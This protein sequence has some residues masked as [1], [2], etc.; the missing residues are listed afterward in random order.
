LSG[1]IVWAS[2]RAGANL[3]LFV[4]KADGRGIHRL[5]ETSAN[6]ALPVWSPDG[7]QIAF[8]SFSGDLAS[9]DFDTS[10]AQINVMKADGSAVRPLTAPDPQTGAVTW[11]PDGDRLA[12]ATHSHI[13]VMRSDGSHRRALR[14]VEG[15]EDWPSW[16]PDGDL[17]LVT[18]S[19]SGSEEL[20]TMRA[21][22]S[23]PKPLS[24]KGSEG[25]WSPDGRSI[26]FASDRD[27]EPHA[28]N[29][30]DWN[31][32]IY[33]TPRDGARAKRVTRIAGNDHWPPAWSPD[34]AHIAFTADG[35]GEN[36]EIFIADA[37]GSRVLNA[38]QHPARDVF[39]SWHR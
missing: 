7:K 8:V 9:L 20:L 39:P 13:D 6:E 24:Q 16:S 1:R 14:E 25:T 28:E 22:G 3:D 29:P 12:F 38:T 15:Y 11:A 4:M 19:R 5:T 18:S 31:E 2:N 37:D 10:P 17:I 26:A 23:S 36:W 34:G 33:V 27:G 32:E 30:R 21:D 35:C